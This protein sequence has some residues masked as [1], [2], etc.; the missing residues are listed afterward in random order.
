[1]IFSIITPNLN[2]GCF[3]DDCLRSVSDQHGMEVE[4]WV[5]DGGSTDNSEEIVRRYSGVRWLREPDEG[6]ADAINKGFDRATGEWVMWL[7]SDDVLLPGAL[8]RVLVWS[9]EN[10][11][12]DV[13]HGDCTFVR[14]DLSEIRRK[15]D[16]P[17]DEWVLAFGGCW[18]PT[19]ATFLH[20]TV[21]SDGVRLDSSLKN[22][23]DWEFY[24]RLL[25]E[26]RRFSYLPEVLAKFR[27]HGSNL[28]VVH[29]ARRRAEDLEVQ[30]RHIVARGWPRWIGS[31]LM[32]NALRWV[33]KARRVGLRWKTHR[34]LR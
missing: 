2:G 7:N 30:R 9:Q 28:S 18:V 26:G 27:W 20:R 19:T 4:H 25:R 5:I 14:E 12:A 15:R 6:M 22:S 8:R 17:M 31:P 34:R 21:I 16:H 24:L 33:F 23:F 3:L 32:L 10:A 1:M 29:D 11:A 13:I